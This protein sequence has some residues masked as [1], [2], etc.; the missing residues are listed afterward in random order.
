MTIVT[1]VFFVPGVF[2]LFHNLYIQSDM[3]QHED[4]MRH[5]EKS[6][7]KNLRRLIPILGLYL[8][9]AIIET[10]PHAA[11][12][13]LN[14]FHC[15]NH[16]ISFNIL[17]IKSSITTWFSFYFICPLIDRNNKHMYNIQ[18]IINCRKSYPVQ[19]CLIVSLCF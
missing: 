7:R 16:Y 12:A 19:T 13:N 3:I 4:L 9:S 14:S 1:G 2:S 18:L 15:L 17:F 10:P 8:F 6:K 11:A 5:S